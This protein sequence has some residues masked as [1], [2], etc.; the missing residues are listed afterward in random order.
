MTSHNEQ[1]HL[2]RA[3]RTLREEPQP[4]WIKISS[5]VL[6]KARSANRLSF[7]VRMDLTDLDPTAEPAHIS[8]QAVISELRRALT[9]IPG[10]TPLQITLGLEDDVCGSVHVAIAGDYGIGLRALA[11]EAHARV[12]TELRTLLGAATP[13]PK[14]TTLQVTDIIAPP[15]SNTRRALLT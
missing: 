9:A 1:M 8:D 5:S 4:G 15:A 14:A 13:T 12:Q 3:A 6:A 7:P 2:A 10:C 11:E